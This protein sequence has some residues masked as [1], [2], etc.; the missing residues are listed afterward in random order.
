M[1]ASVTLACHY[2]DF[3]YYRFSDKNSA[4]TGRDGTYFWRGWVGWIRISAGTDGDGCE[5]CGDVHT[6]TSA[7][8]R[9]YT[10]AR[11]VI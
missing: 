10:R 8:W 4:G 3:Y 1:R 7:Q 6:S 11:Q 2:R 9:G 5:V